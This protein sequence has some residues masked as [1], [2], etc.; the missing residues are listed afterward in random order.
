MPPDVV[1]MNLSQA[2]AAG[3]ASVAKA[4]RPTVVVLSPIYVRRSQS[5]VDYVG[6]RLE[7][8]MVRSAWRI[9]HYML[10]GKTGL[11]GQAAAVG[12]PLG[13]SLLEGKKSC[14]ACT[15]LLWR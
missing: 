2:A 3:G 11:L 9:T 8:P 6:R 4:P 5:H 13:G 7:K 15:S 1:D 12:M 14:I 10:D